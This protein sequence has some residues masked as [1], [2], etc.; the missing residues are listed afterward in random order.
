VTTGQL[1]TFIDGVKIVDTFTVTTWTDDGSDFEWIKI[2][3]ANADARL[4]RF[5]PRR[6]PT[7]ERASPTSRP[8]D[9]VLGRSVDWDVYGTGVHVRRRSSPSAIWATR[10]ARR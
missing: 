4:M 9:I 1:R 2:M 6:Y 10:G 3:A 7:R 8:F 5:W